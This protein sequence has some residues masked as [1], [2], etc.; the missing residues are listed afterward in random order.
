ML[1][2]T[3]QRADVVLPGLSWAEQDGTFTNLERRVQR[4]P[5]ALGNPHSKAAPDWMILSHLATHFDVQWPFSAA[6]AVTQEITV[7]N[8]LYSGMTWERIGDQ[9]QQWFVADAPYTRPEPVYTV[10]RSLNC[11]RSTVGCA[12]STARRSTTAATCSA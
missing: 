12:W 7:A 10:V 3:A 1:T 11:R 2:E 6:R 9:G 5:K 4:A 8:P